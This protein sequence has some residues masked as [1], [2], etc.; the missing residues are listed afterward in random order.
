MVKPYLSISLF[1]VDFYGF[2]SR[3]IFD[4]IYA[5]HLARW[6]FF[7]ALILSSENLT[8]P[9]QINLSRFSIFLKLGTIVWRDRILK[10]TKSPRVSNIMQQL[11]SG[12]FCHGGKGRG[13]GCLEC[14]QRDLKG[15]WCVCPAG[16]INI[17]LF[18]P[19][20]SLIYREVWSQC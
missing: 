10:E 3:F 19:E 4:T 16:I 6:S 18:L 5:H 7:V 12:D 15:G 13:H 14:L 1:L 17:S 8:D 2:S 20:V 9:V 11:R